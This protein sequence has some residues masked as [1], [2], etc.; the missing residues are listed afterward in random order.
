MEWR[1]DGD[2]I[3][4]DRLGRAGLGVAAGVLAILVTAALTGCGGSAGAPISRAAVR[5]SGTVGFRFS[6]T[7]AGEAAGQT[8]TI[9]GAGSLE[10]GGRR[11]AADLVSAGRLVHEVLAAPAVYVQ[12][13]DLPGGIRPPTTPWLKLN[14]ATMIQALGASGPLTGGDPSQVLALL[15]ASGPGAKIGQARVRGVATTHYRARVDLTRYVSLV[16]PGLRAA[17]RRESSSLT[18]ASGSASLP[19]DV[20][21]DG[22]GRVRQVRLRLSTC[23]GTESTTVEYYG[24]G[25]QP[26]VALPSPSQVTDVTRDVAAQVAGAVQAIGRC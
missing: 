17:A 8:F 4:T 3:S 21:L 13:P 16:A 25:S 19:V 14:L 23:A 22:A 18:R 9:Q 10:S 2:L 26:P 5:T 6:L 15:R 24:F 7:V 12:T 11:G 20:W 1:R